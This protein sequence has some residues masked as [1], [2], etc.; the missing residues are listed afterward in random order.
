RN[1]PRVLLFLVLLLWR[2]ERQAVSFRLGAVDRRT[3][4]ESGVGEQRGERDQDAAAGGGAALQLELVDRREPVLPVERGRLY[5]KRRGREGD[6]ADTRVTRLLVDERARCVLRGR[7]TIRLD[8]LRAH[9]ARNVHRQDD[10][11]L[12]RWQRDHRD[13]ATDREQQRGDCQQHQHR[14]N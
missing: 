7:E 8:I 4:V 3:H 6:H 1:R 14:W 12:L 5:E 10:R 9:A 11:F 2:V 13:R